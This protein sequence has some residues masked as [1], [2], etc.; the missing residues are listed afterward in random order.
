MLLDELC[1]EIT[2]ITKHHGINVEQAG[3]G[4]RYTF[5]I[6]E[7]AGKRF[8]G[9]SYTPVEDLTHGDSEAALEA[10][11]VLKEGH[12]PCSLA[13]SPY[14]LVKSLLV[15]YL[16]SLTAHVYEPSSNAVGVDVL[17]VMRFSKQDVVA[18]VGYIGPVIK[19]LTGKVKEIIV[20][21][22]NPR[23]RGQALPDVSV[24]R[25]LKKATKVVVTG[26]TL[27]NDTIDLVLE[28][29]TNADA[30]ALVGATASLYPEPLFRRGISII[31]GFRILPDNVE[32]VANAL[33][34][35]GG[36]GEVYRYG[37]KYTVTHRSST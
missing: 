9:M 35:G 36:T 25:A 15:A 26:A 18:V 6:T 2:S 23:R 30:V 22:R 8:L 16:N 27:V 37:Y 12:D 11:E 34:L 7:S 5:V 28:H 17:D 4:V 13:E 20:L 3:V 19:G 32:K 33:M 31:A 21:E 24:P 29:S 1:R 14:P 10:Y